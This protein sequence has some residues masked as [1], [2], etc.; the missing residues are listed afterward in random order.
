MGGLRRGA[1]VGQRFDVV[2]RLP[3]GWKMS[4]R[5]WRLHRGGARRPWRAAQAPEEAEAKAVAGRRTQEP[6][7]IDDRLNDY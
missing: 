1:E 5:G 4:A 3:T 7:Q 6:Q 2:E